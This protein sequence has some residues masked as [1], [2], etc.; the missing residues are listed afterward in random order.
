MRVSQSVSQS[1]AQ[2]SDR[3]D[4]AESWSFRAGWGGSLLCPL[5]VQK[6]VA[7]AFLCFVCLLLVLVGLTR[8]KITQTNTTKQ[9]ASGAA[10]ASFSSHRP[11]L[12]SLAPVLIKPRTMVPCLSLSTNTCK[13]VTEFD[14]IFTASL[15][16]RRP[17]S[18]ARTNP[19]PMQHGGS[20]V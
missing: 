9:Q 12:Q 4:K 1:D 20:P 2:G 14:F 5:W 10:S 7:I 19:A 17:A 6:L 18:R 11:W 15:D 16:C 8:F 13:R 3:E